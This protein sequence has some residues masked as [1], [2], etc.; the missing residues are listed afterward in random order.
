MVKDPKPDGSYVVH[1]YL[2][3]DGVTS[4]WFKVG[5]GVRQGRII[6]QDFFMEPVNWIMERTIHKGFTGVSD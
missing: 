5:C 6:A 3:A 2:H 1:G 4:D